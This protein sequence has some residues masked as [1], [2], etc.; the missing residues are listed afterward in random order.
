MTT[1][2]WGATYE[3][4]HLRKLSKSSFISG[5]M[6]LLQTIKPNILYTRNEDNN[7]HWL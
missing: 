2:N 7:Y 4:G 5:F 1:V 6:V 3:R